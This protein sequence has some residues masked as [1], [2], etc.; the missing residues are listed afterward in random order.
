M[1]V[2]CNATSVIPS[3]VE[4]FASS[5]PLPFSRPPPSCAGIPVQSVP[6][7]P[8]TRI[9]LAHSGWPRCA[10]GEPLAV[11]AGWHRR[12]PAE[13]IEGQT[14][15]CEAPLNLSCHGQHPD[16]PDSA[17]H[18]ASSCSPHRSPHVSASRLSEYARTST[19]ARLTDSRQLDNRESHKTS[20][21][22]QP[23]LST[24]HCIPGTVPAF[25]HDISSLKAAFRQPDI[26]PAASAI[27][28]IERLVNDEQMN[29][30]DYVTM[31]SAPLFR[32]QPVSIEC[33]W[34]IIQLFIQE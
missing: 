24:V 29:G 32:A 10:P 17:L 2:P 34:V 33:Q 14:A 28:N 9:S 31:T 25:P 30:R 18:S 5:P 4:Q 16:S 13:P 3:V 22:Q 23:M 6:S 21:R 11:Q 1:E 19:S 12:A 8:E 15:S 20:P 7:P 26:M 27:E